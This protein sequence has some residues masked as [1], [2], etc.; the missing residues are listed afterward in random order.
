MTVG[1]ILKIYFNDKSYCELV[2]IKYWAD[3]NA[4]HGDTRGQMRIKPNVNKKSRMDSGYSNGL[5]ITHGFFG[6]DIKM[7][8]QRLQVTLQR[9]P[10]LKLFQQQIINLR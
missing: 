6:A 2:L 10:T 7:L 3:T 8:S 1:L 5:C 9:G 4:S